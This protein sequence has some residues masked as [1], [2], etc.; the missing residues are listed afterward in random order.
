[1]RI[2]LQRYMY[3]NTGLHIIEANDLTIS[4]HSVIQLEHRPLGLKTRV[5]SSESRCCQITVKFKQ[6]GFLKL[7]CFLKDEDNRFQRNP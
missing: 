7:S 5:E 6:K 3:L 4:Q 1:M 2:T